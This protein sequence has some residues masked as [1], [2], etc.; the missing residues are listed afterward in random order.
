MTPSRR[1][2]TE[3][4]RGERRGRAAAAC[5]ARGVSVL[6][7]RR[8]SGRRRRNDR[9]RATGTVRSRVEDVVR[10]GDDQALA[11]LVER[12]DARTRER[13]FSRASTG[14]AATRPNATTP[15]P[16]CCRPRCA[17]SSAATFARR[18]HTWGRTS[19]ASTSA[20]AR[21]SPRTE[22]AAVEDR[23]NGWISLN[24]PV[25]AITTTLDEAKRLG[26]MA[27]SVRSTATS[28][29]WSRSARAST[30]ASCA[31][32]R[33][34]ARPQRSGRSGS[35]RETSSSANVRRIEALTGPAAVDLL[36]EHDRLLARDRPPSCGPARQDVPEAVERP[37]QERKRLEKAVKAGAAQGRRDGRRGRAGRRRR[38]SVAGA[39]V[40]AVTV[41]VP[42]AKALLDAADRLK[43]RLADA[44]ILLGT[45]ADGTG[46]PRR[47]RRARPGRARREGRRRSSR[48]AAAGRRRRRRW[49]RHMAQAGGRDPE[50]LPRGDRGGRGGDRGRAR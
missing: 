44:A 34:F 43:G 3:S 33:T 31:A 13:A 49:P 18:A 26:A 22:I 48:S 32:G 9:M 27:L 29:G 7:G 38:V 8:R 37:R 16:T 11:V 46:S 2:R 50:K 30:R 15:R 25:R 41:E 1:S 42:D 40:L 21:R 19:F 14:V 10:L 17:R 5:E 45:A 24:D 23:V 6:R 39:Q 12:G 4:R 20:T 47:E 35:S 28:C 36:R